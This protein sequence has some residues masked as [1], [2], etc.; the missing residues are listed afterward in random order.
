MKKFLKALGVF[1][2]VGC[3]GHRLPGERKRQ[4]D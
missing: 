3:I 2:A 1:F 4:P